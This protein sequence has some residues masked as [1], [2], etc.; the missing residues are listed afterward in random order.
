VTLG[1]LARHNAVRPQGVSGAAG[2]RRQAVKAKEAPDIIHVVLPILF[3]HGIVPSRFDQNHRLLT[4]PQRTPSRTAK[5]RT[6][7]WTC[8]IQKRAKIQIG[9][10]CQH[11]SATRIR[12]KKCMAV[13]C[14]KLYRAGRRFQVRSENDGPALCLLGGWITRE[15]DS[16]IESVCWA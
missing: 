14:R 9:A 6:P 2:R 15:N 7:S 8:N 13:P 3:I 5:T 4:I 11:K 16:A 10:N 1:A 12:S